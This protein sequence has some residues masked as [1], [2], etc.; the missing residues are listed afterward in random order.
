[1]NIKKNLLL[2][3]VMTGISIAQPY[4]LV[5]IQ[6]IQTVPDSLIGTDPPSPL[7][8]DT[9]RVQGLVLVRPV[10]DPDTNRRVI[11]SAGARWVTYIQDP[12][13]NLW[14]GLNI[15]QEDTTITGQGTF[16][17]LV[18]TAQIVEFTGRIT[19]FNTTTEILL[20]TTPQPIPVEIIGSQPERPAP[21]ELEL[22]D[23]FTPGGGYNYDAEKYEGMYVIFD[24]VITSDRESNGEFKINDQTGHSAFIYNQ[25][26]YFKSAS[27]GGE[28]GWE[29][30][31]DGSHIRYV[32]G[33]VTTRT[34]GYYI[35]PVYPNDVG[36]ILVQPPS[37]SSIRRNTVEVGPNQPVEISA[38][39]QDID[40]TVDNAK[41]FY[42]VNGGVRDSVEMT[43]ADSIFSGT[44]PGIP[45][46]AVV[47]FYV[48]SVD[49][50]GNISVNPSDTVK[51]NYFYLVLNRPITVKDVQYSPFGS[52]YSAFHNYRITLTGVITSDTTGSSN[53]TGGVANRITM[54]DGE[55]PWSGIGLNSLNNSSGVDVYSLKLGDIVTVS[56]L[57]G[58]DFSPTAFT[59]IDS[60]TSIDIISSNNTLPEPQI[61]QTGLIGTN[62]NGFLAAEQWESV[63]ISFEDVL[64]TDKNADG[65]P[66]NFG[67]FFISDGSGNVRVELQDGNH[68]YHN[69]W[70]GFNNIPGAVEIEDSATI[71]KLTGYLYFSFSFYKLVPRYNTDFEGYQG[72]LSVENEHGIPVD[73]NLSQNYPNPFNPST[74][75]LYS[76][77]KSGNVVIKI[78]NVLGQEVR[79]LVDQF[80]TVGNYKVFFDAG[81][82]SSGVYFYSIRSD[83]FVQVKKMMLVK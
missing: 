57:I 53:R 30:P 12:A 70:D 3:V 41:V 62:P 39:I 6:D 52:G 60:I 4:P 68:F 63:L 47:D 18:D 38:K 13:G 71:D 31:L 20:I 40:G 49:N 50:Q 83:D 73:Y 58:E 29:A 45:D 76:I 10:I 15:L 55:G 23:L 72:P 32:R 79:T 56:G 7:N 24:S 54:Q 48:K 17:D 16:F 11:L 9:V 74:L 67:E 69:A 42:R 27:S 37:I 78:Y 8:G 19:E 14:G 28:I 51:S 61:L 44:I 59:R 81:S 22:S 1:M 5:T 43:S 75:I 77:P 34:D 64:I 46:S 36:E 21:I 35:V 80:Q 33:I 66:S 26:R 82:L 25:S 2:I 65:P